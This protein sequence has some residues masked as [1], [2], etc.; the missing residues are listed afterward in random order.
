MQ[1]MTDEDEPR[2]EMDEKNPTSDDDAA[3]VSSS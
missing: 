1:V 2:D 3:D